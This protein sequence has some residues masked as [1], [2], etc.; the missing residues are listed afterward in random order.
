L[1]KKVYYI[2]FSLALLSAGVLTSSVTRTPFDHKKHIGTDCAFCHTGIL[3]STKASDNNLPSPNKTCVLCHQEKGFISSVIFKGTTRSGSS[4]FNHKKHAGDFSL[5]CDQ[6]HKGVFGNGEIY[7]SMESCR[8][9]HDPET[10]MGSC[11]QCHKKKVRFPHAT[12]LKSGVDCQ[13]CHASVEKSS[14]TAGGP[15][16]PGRKVCKMCHQDGKHQAVVQMSAYRQRY[17]FNHSFHISRFGFDCDTCHEKVKGINHLSPSDIVP[18]MDF[19]TGCHNGQVASSACLLCHTDRVPRPLSHDL[20]W[21]KNHRVRA[22]TEKKECMNCHL[23]EEF[24]VACHQGGEKPSG[25]HSVNYELTHK[26]ESRFTMKNCVSCHSKNECSDCHLARGVVPTGNVIRI[27][28]HPDGWL[29]RGSPQFHGVRSA[30]RLKECTTCH[31][32]ADCDFCH[33]KK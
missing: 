17:E 15:D 26:F 22:A 8:S 28:P 24:C 19:C 11:E 10:A 18:S 3:S 2:L 29:R 21:S 30:T 14:T 9:C 12:H 16:I 20:S 33:F 32:K 5:A 23:S 4:A 7:P 31:V 13:V 27:S 6:C 1:N 25:V